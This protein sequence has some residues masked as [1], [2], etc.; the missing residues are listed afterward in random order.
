MVIVA[1]DGHGGANPLGDGFAHK[2]HPL[3]AGVAHGDGVAGFDFLGG[4]G[5]L[6]VDAHMPGFDLGGRQ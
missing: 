2:E 1:G 3:P 5:V 6:A 4:L